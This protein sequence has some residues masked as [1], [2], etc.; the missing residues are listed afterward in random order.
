MQIPFSDTQMQE[1]TR[2]ARQENVQAKLL[3]PNK[4][5]LKFS[6]EKKNGSKRWIH[7]PHFIVKNAQRQVLA[8]IPSPSLTQFSHEVITGFIPGLS[9]LDNAR[10][11]VMKKVVLSI[12]L[13]NFFPSFLSSEIHNLLGVRQGMR[14]AKT[15]VTTSA[16]RLPQGAPTSP[17]LANWAAY[18]G[19]KELIEFCTNHKIAYTR[20]ADDLTFSSVTDM[21][22]DVVDD[23]IDLINSGIFGKKVRV[24]NNKIKFM[25]RHKQQRVTG[26]VV[27]EKL[28]IPRARRRQLRAFMHDCDTNGIEQALSRFNRNCN[29][30]FGEFSF[31]HLAHKDQAEKYIEQFKELL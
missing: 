10:P 15:L 2:I 25:R 23:L 17:M 27:N 3:E 30:I 28:S 16:G 4:G 1:I 18:Q 31:L 9:I 8:N 6:V 24:A 5:Y 13:K 22:Q 21:D 14:E 26:I 7:A 29:H 19:D 11:H 12:D 20:Y